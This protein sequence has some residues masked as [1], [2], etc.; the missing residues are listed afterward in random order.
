MDY[1]S[2][3][4]APRDF[5]FSSDSFSFDKDYNSMRPG[6]TFAG[7]QEDY[8]DGYAGDNDLAGRVQGNTGDGTGFDGEGQDSASVPGFFSSDQTNQDEH[9]RYGDYSDDDGFGGGGGDGSIG[10]DAD[11]NI[12]GGVSEPGRGISIPFDPRRRR[13]GEIR[14]WR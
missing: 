2:I 14:S 11:R 13:T 7:T 9:T 4:P 12:D 1:E 8:D 5:S 6:D 10:A 3:N